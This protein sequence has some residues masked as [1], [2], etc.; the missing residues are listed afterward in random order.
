VI[1][2]A[3]S[4]LQRNLTLPKHIALE[5]CV[6]SLDYA[7]AAQRA[8]ADRIELCSDLDCGGVTPS[9]RLMQTVRKQLQIPIYVLIRPRAGDF[10]YSAREFQAMRKSIETAKD[11]KM[12]GIVVGILDRNSHID[13]ARTRQL[14]ELAHPLPVTFHRAFDETLDETH[15][16]TYAEHDS[17]EAVIQTGARRLLT[18][19]GRPRAADALSTLRRLVK[20]AG[21]RLSVMPGGGITPANI[22]RVVTA[23]AAREVHGSFLTPALTPAMR[24]AA[25]H[26]KGDGAKRNSQAEQ[27]YRRVLTAALTLR[28]A[29]TVGA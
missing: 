4:R 13:V 20:Q 2:G 3:D 11:L 15:D 22:L 29:A 7:L 27:F 21:N 8:G 24:A 19:G 16:E 12:D 26:R 18:S 6:T 28:S 23:T 14:V 17:L 25:V 10:V 5:I 9:T 1:A